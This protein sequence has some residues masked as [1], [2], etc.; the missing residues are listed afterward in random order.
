MKAYWRCERHL[1]TVA[2][3]ALSKQN[4]TNNIINDDVYISTCLPVGRAVRFTWILRHR[5]DAP[6]PK[7]RIPCVVNRSRTVLFYDDSVIWWTNVDISSGVVFLCERPVPATKAAA[8]GFRVLMWLW[9]SGCRAT[10]Q[11]IVIWHL[12]VDYHLNAEPYLSRLFCHPHN[13]LPRNMHIG[14]RLHS[15]CSANTF[16]PSSNHLLNY[17][18]QH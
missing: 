10:T 4:N 13:M 3:W 9:A 7:K 15:K 14:D 5:I 12:Y 6:R 16:S 1:C 8:D 17:K 18:R 11:V 2:V